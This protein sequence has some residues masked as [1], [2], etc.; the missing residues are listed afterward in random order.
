MGILLACLERV[1]KQGAAV[2]H[3]LHAGEWQLSAS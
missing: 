3:A 1:G 2:Q